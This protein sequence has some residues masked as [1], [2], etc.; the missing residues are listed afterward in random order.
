MGG[1]ETMAGWRVPL[2]FISA[3]GIIGGW[4]AWWLKRP[5]ICVTGSSCASP[6]R[7]TATLALL[8]SASAIVLAAASWSYIDPILLKLW[9]GH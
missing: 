1:L 4:G 2:L 8:L 7:S 6:G 3:L 9:R 5:V